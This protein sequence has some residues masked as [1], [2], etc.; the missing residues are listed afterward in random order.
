MQTVE[1]SIGQSFV[2]E[3]ERGEVTITVVSI[4]GNKVTLGVEDSAS[5]QDGYQEVT[6][7]AEDESLLE[8]LKARAR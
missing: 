4:A 6:L 1:C 3:H 5:T 7:T 2:V 8:L